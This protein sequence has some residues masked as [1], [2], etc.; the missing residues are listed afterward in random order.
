MAAALQAIEG[1][2][3]PQRR[4][5]VCVC[6]AARERRMARVVVIGATGHVGTYLVP[7][8][9]AAGHAVVAIS[10]GKAE[11]YT[12]S[13][14][15]DQVERLTMDRE[16]MEAAGGFGAAIVATR[17]DVVVDM[18]CFEPASARHLAEALAGKVGQYVLVGT[19][20]TYGPTVVAPTTE[21]AAKRPFGDYGVKKAEIE[22][23]LLGLAR[24]TGFPA[25][26]V[27][28]GHIVGPGWVPLNPAGNFNPQVFSMLARGEELALPNFGLETVHHVH[29]D[30]VAA[31][32]MA[33]IGN[34][35]AAKGEAFNAVSGGAVTLRGYAEAMAAWFGQPANLSFAP[36][37]AWKAGQSAEDANATWEHIARSPCHSMEKARRL[38]GFV[39]RFGSLE[40]VE[41]AVT[42][43][44]GKGVVTLPSR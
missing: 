3:L 34:W 33:T 19:I 6:R 13:A 23:Y 27:H 40:A 42:A 1:L 14:A 28:P 25:T 38:L 17:P 30:D 2:R 36:Y 18:I 4:E 8:L 15:W 32:I 26:I 39:P 44:I 5:S 35:S 9:V 24:T 37:E 20:W 41:E 7:R 43:L 21:E 10:R 11:P 22:A 29:A 12:P 31:L 16:K